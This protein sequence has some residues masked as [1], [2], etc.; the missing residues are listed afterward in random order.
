MKFIQFNTNQ[1]RRKKEAEKKKCMV[2]STKFKDI[3]KSKHSS[4]HNKYKKT[5]LTS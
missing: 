3:K 2:N 4:N 1:K 5:K